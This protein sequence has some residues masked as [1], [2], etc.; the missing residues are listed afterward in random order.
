MAAGFRTTV[1][2]PGLAGRNLGSASGTKPGWRTVVGP[3]ILLRFGSVVSVV[4]P[5]EP[6][7]TPEEEAIRAGYAFRRNLVLQDEQDLVE[8]L[9]IWA[10]ICDN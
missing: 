9:G 3:P 5:V 2:P 8:I 1:G 7:V 10:T 6:P 4:P